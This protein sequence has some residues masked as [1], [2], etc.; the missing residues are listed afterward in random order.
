[1][2]RVIGISIFVLAVL[3]LFAACKSPSNSN[4]GT[5]S[6]TV[7]FDKNGGDTEASPKTKTVTSPATTVETLP[8]APSRENYDFVEWNTAQNGSGS[9]FSATTTVTADI[10]VYAKWTLKDITPPDTFT[11]NL[12]ITGNVAGDSVTVTPESGEDGDTITINYTLAGGFVNNRLVFSGVTANIAQVDVAE[13]GTRTYTV[14][15]GDADPVTGVITINATFTHTDKDLDTI[16][17]A[18]NTLQKTYGDPG[19]TEVVSNQG[20]GTGAITYSSGDETVATVVSTTGAV[21]ILKA[22]SATITATKAADDDYEGTTADY[23]LHVAQLQL[24]IAAPTGTTTKTYDTTT[25]ASGITAGTL[26]NKVGSD[27]VAVTVA[28]ATYNSPDVVSANSI[29][30]VY[31]ISGTNAG[32]YIKPVD[33]VISG[34]S[35]TKAAGATLSVNQLATVE[36]TTSIQI[37]GGVTAPNGQ[38][39]QYASALKDAV[40]P[41]LTF[42][43]STTLE[44]LSPNT[45]YDI[46]A[47]A[48]AND[49]YNDGDPIKVGT[50]TTEALPVVEPSVP[51]TIVN[52]EDKNINDTYAITGGSGSPT[53]QVVDDPVNS[54]EKSLRVYS[55]GWNRGAIIPINL[56]FAV[57]N[58][59]SFTLRFYLPDTLMI[60]TNANGIPSNPLVVYVTPS[61]FTF[62]SNALGNNT[63]N[64]TIYQVGSITQSELTGKPNQWVDL[65]INPSIPPS[66]CGANSQNLSGDLNLVIGINHNGNITYLFDDLT[67][68][69][70]PEFTP[71][72]AISPTTAMFVK[73][74]TTPSPNYKDIV[75]EMTLYGNTLTGINNNGAQL[76]RGSDYTVTGDKNEI[77]T[78]KKD[79]L[80]SL[81][82]LPGTLTE[83]TLTFEFNQGEVRERDIV[84]TIAATD[85][86]LPVLS[87]NFTNNPGTIWRYGPDEPS[88]PWLNATWNSAGYLSVSILRRNGSNLPG[89]LVLPFNLG[90]A[91]L[92]DFSS[93]R[94]DLASGNNDGNSKNSFKVEV[95]LTRQTVEGELESGN[96]GPFNA[97]SSNKQIAISS[98]STGTAGLN[99]FNLRNYSLSLDSTTQDL[100]GRVDLGFGISE[101]INV[102]TIYLIKSIELVRPNP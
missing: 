5:T 63:A 101:Y 43:D 33:F 7:T 8:T 16:A 82:P 13:T 90:N 12:S 98:G 81:L 78:L 100:K 56:P 77:V 42:G 102:G 35:I 76:S 34:A 22:G 47:R 53:V 28:S 93:I 31:A 19:F 95:S 40:D 92:S 71:S 79:Y 69:I 32:N 21:T 74:S 86:D 26:T 37:T 1:M 70:D 17:F 46:W 10:T 84:I 96:T 67:F 73:D 99:A 29:T 18:D 91:K 49:N 30:V 48:K 14:D 61:T 38:A 83:A 9:K 23:T 50:A 87:Y 44:G 88:N 27:D 97:I 54:G 57:E 59:K 65:E 25:T 80:A 20:Q 52:F 66:G 89:A 94:I 60:N 58:Y 41:A 4:S 36:T 68:N 75:V 62:P 11:I 51:P 85:A 64:V 45:A 6:Y 2:K 39:I 3:T 24:T 55:T 15:A 72:S